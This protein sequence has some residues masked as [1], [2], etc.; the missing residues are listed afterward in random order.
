M[1]GIT[2]REGKTAAKG[3][4][5]NR[6]KRQ[7]GETQPKIYRDLGKNRGEGHDGGEKNVFR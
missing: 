2:R 5:T 1:G 7:I 4:G 6:K 3:A